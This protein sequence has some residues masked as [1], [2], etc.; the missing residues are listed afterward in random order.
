VVESVC[1]G[2]D[3]AGIQIYA[4]SV[5][6]RSWRELAVLAGAWRGNGVLVRAVS[7]S[8]QH[9]SKQHTVNTIIEYLFYIARVNL[10]ELHLYTTY[11]YEGEARK[12]EGSK[13]HHH[14]LLRCFRP[15]VII[16]FLLESRLESSKAASDS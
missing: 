3:M 13:E 1:I 5:T 7:A 11:L 2:V 10:R 9:C 16:P 12:E 14:C 4:R 8:P 6:A 15:R